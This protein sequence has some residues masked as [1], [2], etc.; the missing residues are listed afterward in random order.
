MKHRCCNKV[1]FTMKKFATFLFFAAILTSCRKEKSLDRSGG[2]PNAIF[3]GNNCKMS[4]ILNVDS[5]TNIAW[6]A[7]NIFYNS[8]GLAVR[9]EVYDSIGLAPYSNDVYTYRGDTVFV[10]GNSGYFVRNSSGR[11]VL[12]R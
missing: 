4:Q 2:D 12:F 5:T 9:S 11:V 8:T 6:E 3:L 7:H 1:L 10:N